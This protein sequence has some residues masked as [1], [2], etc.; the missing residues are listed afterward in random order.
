MQKS[1]GWTCDECEK[2]LGEGVGPTINHI[3]ES[4]LT[5]KPPKIDVGSKVVD[6]LTG[7]VTVVTKVL[8]DK[9]GN[10]GYIINSQCLDGK[11]LAWEVTALY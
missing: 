5:A 8:M 4:C 7:E 6:D 2:L 9:S 1:Y 10:L 3:C 11:R